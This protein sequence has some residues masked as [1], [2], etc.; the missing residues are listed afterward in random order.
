MGIFDKFN[1]GLSKTRKFISESLTKIAAGMGSFD[2]DMLDDLEMLLVSADVGA[3]TSMMMMDN[4]RDRIKSTGNSSREAVIN[5]LKEEMVRILGDP[6]RYELSEGKLN[7][8]II[9][10][11]NGTGKTTTAGKLCLRFMSSG[12]KVILAA[13][14]T[15]RAAAIEQLRH[16]GELNDAPV[17]AH[18]TGSDPGAVVFDAVHAAISREAD[19]LIIDTA[20]R[21]HNKKNL[22]EEFAKISRIAAREAP[23]ADIRVILV[24]DATTGQNAVVQAKIFNEAAKIDGII[25]TKLDSNAKGGIAVAVVYETSIPVI[26]AGLGEK[27]EDLVDFEPVSFID[28]LFDE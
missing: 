16:W 17:I 13:A 5:T 2:E 8:I 14:D 28:S 3:T 15:F 11:V 23:D 21:L 26:M 1:A 4:V 12:K 24:V 7:I 20:G 22:M 25:L 10:G 19:V 9:A 27:A 18:E 6:V